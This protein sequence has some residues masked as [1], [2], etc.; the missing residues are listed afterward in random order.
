MPGRFHMGWSTSVATQGKCSQMATTDALLQPLWRTSPPLPLFLH[1]NWAVGHPMTVLWQRWV[2]VSVPLVTSLPVDA[3]GGGWRCGC[4][5]RGLGLAVACAHG[6]VA[7]ALCKHCLLQVDMVCSLEALCAFCR[8]FVCFGGG[9]RSARVC[10]GAKRRPLLGARRR[11]VGWRSRPVGT[12]D[13]SIPFRWTAGE[14][15]TGRCGWRTCCVEVL[16]GLFGPVGTVGQTL[17]SGAA[18][19]RSMAFGT[20]ET[21]CRGFPPHSSRQLSSM[22]SPAD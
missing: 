18:A 9:V 21:A 2:M 22:V 14:S 11:S 1:I 15:S 16:A 8:R 3:F 19:I 13:R 17:A 4:T 20:A 10:V 12:V 5:H 7:A 6:G